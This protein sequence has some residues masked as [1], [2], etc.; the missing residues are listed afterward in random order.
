MINS[1]QN[2]EDYT[3]SALD[4]SQVLGAKLQTILTKYDNFDSLESEARLENWVKR[5]ERLEEYQNI[6]KKEIDDLK[7]G[8]NFS[9]QKRSRT[10]SR[11]HIKVMKL[12]RESDL[13][14]N[15]SK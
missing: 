4:M 14:K 11:R 6:A 8:I 15:L 3:Y 2:C 9:D 10:L 1:A 5:T 7:D 12:K 13:Q